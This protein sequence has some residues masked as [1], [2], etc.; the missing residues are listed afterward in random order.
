MSLY[1]RENRSSFAYGFRLLRSAKW[2]KLPA[3]EQQKELVAKR[4]GKQRASFVDSESGDDRS[5]RIKRLTKG[6]A[7]NIL[8]R[9]KHGAQVRSSR[10]RF[11]LLTRR[12]AAT[13]REEGE[14]GDEGFES[15][16]QG[17]TS[18]R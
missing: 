17:V 2:R 10:C 7:A 12:L 15:F 9:L 4:W 11:Q 13:I 8:T 14:G 18:P 6:E 3:S 5:E 16:D 1:R